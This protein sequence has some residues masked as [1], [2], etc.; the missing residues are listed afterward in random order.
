[1]VPDPPRYSAVPNALLCVTSTLHNV[2]PGCTAVMQA[3]PVEAAV[4]VVSWRVEAG[5]LRY[6]QMAFELRASC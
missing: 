5:A 1:V 6:A 2:V 4:A 3:D